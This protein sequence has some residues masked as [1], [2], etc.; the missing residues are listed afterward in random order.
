MLHTL[1]DFRTFGGPYVVEYSIRRNGHA[2]HTLGRATWADWDQGGR[3]VVA[4]HGRLLTWDEGRGLQEL[5]DFN[6][7]I[8][9]PQPA[10]DWATKW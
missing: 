7:Q 1:D 3:L 2:E 5:T 6:D 4:E 8:P 10:P 9:D